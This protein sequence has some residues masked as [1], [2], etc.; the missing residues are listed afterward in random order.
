MGGGGGVRLECRGWKGGPWACRWQ[1]RRQPAG[2]SKRALLHVSLHL[3][4][5][6]ASQPPFQPTPLCCAQAN[7]AILNALLTLLNER[8]FDNGSERIAVPLTCLVRRGRRCV[9]GAPATAAA[10]RAPCGPP[11]PAALAA[12]APCL[13]PTLSGTQ[14][15]LP[16]CPPPL[17]LPPG[18]RLQRAAR[19]RGAGR[20]VRPLP[21]PPQRGA[22]GGRGLVGVEGWWGG[23]RTREGA[24]WAY[25]SERG[26]EG[27]GSRES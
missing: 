3:D 16:P 11:S 9:P 17:C 13:A 20:A 1:R 27:D 10:Q 14:P 25:C 6:P 15:P 8:L 22:G 24:G 18:G 23:C 2:G 12:A 7:S 4:A 21:H 5:P 26:R 19:E